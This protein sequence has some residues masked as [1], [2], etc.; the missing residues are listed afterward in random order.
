MGRAATA[1]QQRTFSR[2]SLVATKTNCEIDVV[3]GVR[4]VGAR[5]YVPRTLEHTVDGPVEQILFPNYAFVFL[6]DEWR[7]IR[8]VRGVIDFVYFDGAPCTVRSSLIEKLRSGVA[9][10]LP[11]ENQFGYHV[12][13]NRFRAGQRVRIEGGVSTGVVRSMDGKARV[14][15]LFQML[16]QSTE[17]SL[18]AK[19]LIA[20]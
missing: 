10:G 15:V 19:S 7:K 9:L 13:G 8:T 5:A 20:A 3:R 6:D 12:I 2:I 4:D 14:R 11:P 18:P 17:V 1:A 16:G